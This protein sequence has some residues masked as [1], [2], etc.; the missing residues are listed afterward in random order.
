MA[1]GIYT[2][3]VKFWG[4]LAGLGTAAFT[5][6][7]RMVRGRP[8]MEPHVILGP[9]GQAIGELRIDAPVY[10]R[11]YNPGPLTI[12]VGPMR[13]R[14]SEAKRP[15]DQQVAMVA[16]VGRDVHP[17]RLFSIP[18]GS[19]GLFELVW[20]DPEDER[21]F[22]RPFSIVVSW[23]PLNA[24]LRR[25]PLRLPTSLAALKRLQRDELHLQKEDR[26]RRG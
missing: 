26:Q 4:G 6:W 10:L 23:R 15:K 12:G 8:W 18:A 25:P 1:D 2:E 3:A 19:F 11:I 21:D 22:D 9:K 24:R 14:G 16:D 17:Q 20:A 5:I 13:L 7:D